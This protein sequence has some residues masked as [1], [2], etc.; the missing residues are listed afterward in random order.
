MKELIWQIDIKIIY[1]LL[2]FVQ[3]IIAS[4]LGILTYRLSKEHIIQGT[5]RK[6]NESRIDLINRKLLN[7]KDDKRRYDEIDAILRHKG[8]KYYYSNMQPYN[9]ISTK[10]YSAIF[11]TIV[12]VFVISMIHSTAII[13]GGVI[14]G[15]LGYNLLDIYTNYLDKKDNDKIADDVRIIL[16]AMRVQGSANIYITDILQE[17]YYEIQNKRLKAA[18]LEFTGDIRAKKDIGYTVDLLGSKFNNKYIDSLCVVIKQ[19]L[20]SGKSENMLEYINKQM[21]SMQK[22]MIVRDKRL[23]EQDKIVS[24]FIVFALVFAF[25]FINIAGVM[26]LDLF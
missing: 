20:K 8:Y 23:V 7:G 21:L 10:I 9:Y 16:A 11:G 25:I 3:T 13:I 2:F 24:T 4:S 15:I 26:S 6:L 14:G 17:C 19:Q 1:L 18:L 22:E 12:G 5:Y